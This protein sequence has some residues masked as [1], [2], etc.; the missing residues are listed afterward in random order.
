MTAWVRLEAWR[1][2]DGKS[3]LRGW[4]VSDPAPIYLKFEPDDWRRLENEGVAPAA[5]DRVLIRATFID[6][7]RETAPEFFD[8]VL[9]WLRS[10]GGPDDVRLVYRIGE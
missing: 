4:T 8:V 2:W 9:P 6:R 5:E 10:L 3:S 7:M 1:S